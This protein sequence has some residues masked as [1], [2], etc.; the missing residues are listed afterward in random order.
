MRP[1]EKQKIEL[2]PKRK[3]VIS[4]IL[5]H[6]LFYCNNRGS[7]ALRQKVLEEM[8]GR[9]SYKPDSV[10]VVVTT[11]GSHCFSSS[12]HT[13]LWHVYAL[14]WLKRRQEDSLGFLR[15]CTWALFQC[16]CC[17]ELWEHEESQGWCQVIPVQPWKGLHWGGRAEPLLS[18][19]SP[20]QF[21]RLPQ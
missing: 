9:N 15:K 5:V 17:H 21:C 12:S 11:A 18:E 10:C 8:N 7:R 4:A 20:Y 16:F 1:F 14:R 6:F 19:T 2:L 13:F 3:R